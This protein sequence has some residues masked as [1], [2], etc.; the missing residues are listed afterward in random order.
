[1]PTIIKWFVQALLAAL[2]EAGVA[3]FK[4]VQ[5]IKHANKKV[6]QNESAASKYEENP[7]PD[8]Y[9]DLP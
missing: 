6:E 1:M 2:I 3:I 7:S 4:K 5:K 8:N 9:G